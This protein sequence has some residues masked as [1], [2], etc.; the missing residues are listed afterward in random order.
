MTIGIGIL[1]AYYAINVLVG[2]Y[3]AAEARTVRYTPGLVV[4]QIIVWTGLVLGVI[5][6]K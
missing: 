6:W 3:Y 2:I 4:M 1:I 5:F